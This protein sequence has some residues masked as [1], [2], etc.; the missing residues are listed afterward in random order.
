MFHR[1]DWIRN[2]PNRAPSQVRL[3]IPARI[4]LDLEPNQVGDGQLRQRMIRESLAV[5]LLVTERAQ[6]NDHPPILASR[7]VD[8]MRSLDHPRTEPACRL[9]A[10]APAT[11]PAERFSDV[12]EVGKFPQKVAISSSRVVSWLI[13]HRSRT[14]KPAGCLRTF[15]TRR[16]ATSC[17]DSSQRARRSNASCKVSRETFA[18]ARRYRAS[19]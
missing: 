9:I 19:P 12:R 1:L 6:L 10:L 11:G 14:R 18:D 15:S 7:L 8:D 16:H 17:S 13:P 4:R 3:I 2:A 5:L